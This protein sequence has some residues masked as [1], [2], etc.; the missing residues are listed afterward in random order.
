MSHYWS[1]IVLTSPIAAR[2]LNDRS[3]AVTGELALRNYFKRGL[4]AYLNLAFELLGVMWGLS[5]VIVL[6]QQSKWHDDGSVYGTR[7]E[8]KC[9]QGR[10]KLQ[11]LDEKMRI[12]A[13]SPGNSFG[14]NGGD[15]ETRTR[16]F[17]RDSCVN[18]FYNN[19]Q[20]TRGLPNAAQ[21]A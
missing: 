5:S 7:C 15:D 12:A 2:L 18:R 20:D 8:L 13:P 17:C 4:E 9:Y 19:L 16:D 1:E 3:G 11:P 14:R 21:V 6:L 10:R